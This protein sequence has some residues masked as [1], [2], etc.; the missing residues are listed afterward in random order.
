LLIVNYGFLGF[1]FVIIVPSAHDEPNAWQPSGI[2]ALRA[3][4]LAQQKSTRCR[5]FAWSRSTSFVLIFPSDIAG[6]GFQTVS[7]SF[8]FKLESG[9]EF[10]AET[11]S[12]Q[13]SRIEFR[14][15][16]LRDPAAQVVV[17][18]HAACAVPDACLQP[19]SIA[20]QAAV[21]YVDRRCYA[22]VIF[23]AVLS[24]SAIG[25]ATHGELMVS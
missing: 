14:R 5:V 6:F 21:A 3:A 16:T 24:R 2:A 17:V 19:R 23:Q 18:A 10:P 15:A 1:Q 4:A 25:F 7:R 9:A 8:F 11:R 22:L 20:E 13:R 12:P